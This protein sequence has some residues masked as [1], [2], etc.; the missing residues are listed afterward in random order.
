LTGSFVATPGAAEGVVRVCV[1]VAGGA[2]DVGMG[3]VPL[4]GMGLELAEVASGG[5]DAG[6][7]DGELAQPP[8]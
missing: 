1:E 7:R 4:D 3:A 2:E 6:G 5:C 8:V